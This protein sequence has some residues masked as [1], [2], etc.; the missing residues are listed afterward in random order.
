LEKQE[1]EGEV[2]DEAHAR[3]VKQR[4]GLVQAFAVLCSVRV[5]NVLQRSDTCADIRTF[6]FQL[7][8]KGENGLGHDKQINAGRFSCHTGFLRI[9]DLSADAVDLSEGRE[10]AGTHETKFACGTCLSAIGDDGIRDGLVPTDNV[11]PQALTRSAVSGRQCAYSVLSDARGTAYKDGR[12]RLLLDQC[13]VAGLNDVELYHDYRDLAQVISGD[14]E[15]AIQYSECLSG[16]KYTGRLM[17]CVQ[18]AESRQRLPLNN[19]DQS[20][21][22]RRKG[23]LG[24]V[25]DFSLSSLKCPEAC[26]PSR[27]G[28][29][30]VD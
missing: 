9:D 20:E 4:Q 28:S 21:M 29:I 17:L 1:A 5:S 23:R 8:P 19:L 2:G 27:K 15:D 18:D 25:M 3:V 11:Q 14:G 10:I 7:S 26:I 30:Q 13:I 12:D 6:P 24:T 16:Y 22:R